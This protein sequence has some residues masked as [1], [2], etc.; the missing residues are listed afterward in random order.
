MHSC[1]HLSASTDPLQHFFFWLKP[2]SGTICWSR[3]S[4]K[5]TH[6][7]T[8]VLEVHKG[9]SNALRNSSVY[10]PTN[11]LH[12]YVFWV[13]TDIGALDLLAYN[14]EAYVHWLNEMGKLA[15]TMHHSRPQ[16]AQSLPIMQ[17]TSSPTL[18]GGSLHGS[19]DQGWTENTLIFQRPSEGMLNSVQTEDRAADSSFHKLFPFSRKTQV[20]PLTSTPCNA[21]A[22]SHRNSFEDDVI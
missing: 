21:A 7:E 13:L 3:E 2:D 17:E 4:S 16:S 6:K 15:Q 22:V 14:E 12:K 8:R 1:R 10:S 9:P 18:Q 19:S 5:K 11:E 20:Q